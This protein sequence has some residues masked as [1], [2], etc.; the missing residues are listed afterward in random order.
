MKE[1]QHTS[2][3]KKEKFNSKLNSKENEFPNRKRN[4]LFEKKS[5]L[6]DNLAQFNKEV[7]HEAT[8]T[9]LEIFLQE[10]KALLL[11]D[12][13]TEQ[14]KSRLTI[15]LKDLRLNEQQQK[16]LKQYATYLQKST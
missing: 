2:E 6:A 7:Q 12:P 9:R 15:R 10:N 14:I 5:N 4:L 8:K 3:L 16:D 13:F 1:I 11:K